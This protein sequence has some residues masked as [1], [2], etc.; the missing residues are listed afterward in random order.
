MSTVKLSPLI[1][2][3]RKRMG[4]IVY[5]RWKNTNYAKQYSPGR[6]GDSERQAEIREAFSTAVLLWKNM[7]HALHGTWNVWAGTL[8]LNMSGYNAFIKA[9]LSRV[10]TGSE[11]ELFKS[12]GE[13]EPASLSASPNPGQ[14]EIACNF[15]MAQGSP[16]RYVIFFALR[17]NDGRVTGEIIMREAGLSPEFPFVI[18][19]LEPGAEY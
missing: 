9:N 14:R 11:P 7:G 3:V 10:L 13:N 8:D 2:D 18:A 4:N 15:T 6:R 19:G 5:S 1:T 16:Q 12:T 17:L